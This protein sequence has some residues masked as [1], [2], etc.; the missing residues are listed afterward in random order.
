VKDRRQ[1]PNF[2]LLKPGQKS[3]SEQDEVGT[4]FGLT[5]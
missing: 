5:T 3:G 1:V 4:D 2:F